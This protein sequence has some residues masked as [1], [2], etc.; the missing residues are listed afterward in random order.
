MKEKL[1]SKKQEI[2]KKIS[3]ALNTKI[4]TIEKYIKQFKNKYIVIKYGGHAMV[5]EKLSTSFTQDISLL[6]KLGIKPIIVHG[7][8]PQI[9][10]MLNELNIESKF[11]GGLRVTNKETIKIVEMVLSGSVNKD[12]VSKIN[13]TKSLIFLFF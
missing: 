9:E 2:V 3:K 4:E 7:G 11:I 10:A 1:M 8:G 5:N 6:D 13:Q 12:I